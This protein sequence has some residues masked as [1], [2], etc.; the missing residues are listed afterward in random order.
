MEDEPELLQCLAALGDVSDSR[1]DGLNRYRVSGR[2]SSDVRAARPNRLYCP[3]CAVNRYQQ[4]RTYIREEIWE[5]PWASSC[6]RDGT[7][8]LEQPVDSIRNVVQ[9][10]Q[11]TQL[12]QAILDAAERTE[13]PYWISDYLDWAPLWRRISSLEVKWRRGEALDDLRVISDI[14][15]VL[16]ADFYP[17]PERSAIALL[18]NLPSVPYGYRLPE[19]TAHSGGALAS[20]PNVHVRRTAMTVAYTL[21]EVAFMKSRLPRIF[22]LTETFTPKLVTLWT[23]IFSFAHPATWKWLLNAAD[24]WPD[25]HACA[26]SFVLRETYVEAD[27][28]F[29]SFVSNGLLERHMKR[30]KNRRTIAWVLAPVH[31]VRPVSPASPLRNEAEP[32]ESGVEQT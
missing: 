3:K 26:V 12:E 17:V 28:F 11:Y 7:P 6:I 30:L 29:E 15:A 16:C 27:A 18:C 8:L 4:G 19:P 22:P 25:R 21:L 13:M 1:R 10:Q 9:M 24:G 14:A 31:R 2:L 32:P 23:T 5:L 20:V